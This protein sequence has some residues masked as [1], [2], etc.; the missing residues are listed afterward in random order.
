MTKTQTLFV[1]S[2]WSGSRSDFEGKGKVLK[3]L[4]VSHLMVISHLIKTSAKSV[5]IDG[6][7]EGEMHSHNPKKKKNNTKENAPQLL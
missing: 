5:E 4:K 7:G 6:R 3:T 1:K 2:G